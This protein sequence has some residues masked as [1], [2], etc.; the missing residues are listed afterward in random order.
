MGTDGHRPGLLMVLLGLAG[1]MFVPATRGEAQAVW[2]ADVQVRRLVVLETGG[3][4]RLDAV[5]AVELGAADAVRLEI[6][7][8]VG[9]GVTGLS[10]GCVG[11]PSPQGVSALRARVVCRFGGLAA[12]STREVHVV[13]TAPPP[14]LPRGFGAVALSDTPDPRPANNFA[15]KTLP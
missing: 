7:L 5:V 6:L 4:L 8:P 12:R 1:G 10:A 11:G 13:T 14:G 3:G 2:Q 9:V 15:E